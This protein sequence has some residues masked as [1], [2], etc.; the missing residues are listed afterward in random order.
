MA[1]RIHELISDRRPGCPTPAPRC[2]RASRWRLLAAE[3][4]HRFADLNP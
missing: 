3:L 2:G 1:E 4:A